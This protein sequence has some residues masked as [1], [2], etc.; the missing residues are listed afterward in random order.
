MLYVII[1]NLI[2]TNRLLGR[3][4]GNAATVAYLQSDAKFNTQ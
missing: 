1:Y 2:N 3:L 4:Q